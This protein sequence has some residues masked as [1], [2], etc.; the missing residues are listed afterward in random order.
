MSE[1]NQKIINGY[2]TFARNSV[3]WYGMTY[4]E[5][6]DAGFLP[7]VETHI[8]ETLSKLKKHENYIKYLRTMCGFPANYMAEMI[9]E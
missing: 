3:A 6:V 9:K 7:S 2:Y 1:S 4:G 5:I 8:R